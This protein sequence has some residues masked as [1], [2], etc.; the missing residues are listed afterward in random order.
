MKTNTLILTIAMT[1]SA[2]ALDA[3][4]KAAGVGSTVTPP[5]LYVVTDL[6]TLGGSNADGVGINNRGWVVGLSYVPGDQS[7]HAFL[8]RDG[9]MSDLGAL[10]GLNSYALTVSNS[11]VIAVSAETVSPDPLSESFCN[12]ATLNIPPTSPT[13]LTCLGAF[14]RDGVL[15]ALPTLGGNN[16]EASGANSVGQVGLG[17]D[18][19]EGPDLC[20]APG[21]RLLRRCLGTGGGGNPRLSSASRR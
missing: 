18:P 1:L 7:E 8:W 10:G 13:G 6:G 19:H 20:R 12:F 21:A 11:G 2:V 14:W 16:G 5:V 9:A 17:G 15:T 3:P 4:V